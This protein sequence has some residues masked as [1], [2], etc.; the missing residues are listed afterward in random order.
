MEIE[1]VDVSRLENRTVRLRSAGFA[2]LVVA[3]WMAL[4][5][6]ATVRA[7]LDPSGLARDFDA[8]VARLGSLDDDER[9]SALAALREAGATAAEALL[10]GLDAT[11]SVVRAA[12]ARLLGELGDSQFGPAL[13]EKV[14][15]TDFTMVR[16]SAAIALA[17]TGHHEAPDVLGAYLL[18]DPVGGAEAIAAGGYRDFLPELMAV[19]TDAHDNFKSLQYRRGADRDRV[20]AEEGRLAG[21]MAV[22]AGAAM[23]L[24]CRGGD[25][26][27]A[28]RREV[29]GVGRRV[30]AAPDEGVSRRRY[31][32]DGSARPRR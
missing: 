9:D 13:A 18:I 16:R 26:A 2:W 17:K 21:D 6:V 23:Q 5:P 7:T 11:S 24:G 14:R 12:C 30:R 20:V 27:D 15:S 3:G 19:L 4:G 31:A 29:H 25:R 1:G 32:V 22:L 28:R 8:E 10:D